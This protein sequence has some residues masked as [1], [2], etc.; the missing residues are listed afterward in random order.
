M[1]RLIK[2]VPL[3]FAHG[4]DDGTWPGYVRECDVFECGGCVECEDEE[5]PEGDGWQV[6]QDV[7][8]GSPI[9]PVF[10]ERDSVVAWLVENEDCAPAAADKFIEDGWAPSFIA[11]PFG[12]FKGVQ[13]AAGEAV[14]IE[15]LHVKA[16]DY[17]T[18]PA[19]TAIRHKESGITGKVNHRFPPPNGE[20]YLVT[21]DR[22]LPS[23]LEGD[24]T[25]DPDAPMDAGC[26][27]DGFD[28]L[29]EV[30]S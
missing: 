22:G 4:P 26:R 11:G 29:A 23:L 24:A 19:G 6:W 7:S 9:S 8:E 3:D 12:M 25:L 30:P 15:W 20:Y 1:S 5:P 2:R 27:V 16:G 13:I 14:A 17:T 28:L 10:A 18:I 21:W